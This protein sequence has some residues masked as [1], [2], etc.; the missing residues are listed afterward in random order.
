MRREGA[1]QLAEVGRAEVATL[2]RPPPVLPMPLLQQQVP[3]SS[4]Y[5]IC[6]RKTM[7]GQRTRSLLVSAPVLNLF[8]PCLHAIVQQAIVCAEYVDVY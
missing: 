4:T 3:Q 6:F 7:R 2:L 1:L 5:V 8:P